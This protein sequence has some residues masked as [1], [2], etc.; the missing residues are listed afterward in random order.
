MSGLRLFFFPHF[1]E[2]FITGLLIVF[3]VPFSLFFLL[4]I[5]FGSLNIKCINSI[6]NRFFC[7]RKAYENIE[8]SKINTILRLIK[9]FF[10]FEL[11]LWIII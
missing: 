2:K 7:K 3:L 1:F 9:Y 11:K 10:N 8:N 4:V 5:S 6:K